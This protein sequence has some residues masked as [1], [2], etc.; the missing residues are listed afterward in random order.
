[1]DIAE[2]IYKEVV[3]PYNYKIGKYITMLTTAEK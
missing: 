2:T 3:H 1:M